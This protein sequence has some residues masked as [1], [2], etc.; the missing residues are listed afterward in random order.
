MATVQLDNIAKSWGAVTAV[1]PLSLDIADGEFLVLLGPSG[2][3]KTTTM[4]MIAGLDEPTGGTIRIDGRDV[5][6]LEPRDRDVAM[7][8]QNY[9]LYPHMTVAENIAY[10]LKL[11]GVPRAER[12]RRV[13]EAAARVE[14][15]PYLDRRPAAMSGGQRQ[16][17]A[18]ARAIVRQ[19]RLFL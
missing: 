6:H 9:G 17:V 15:T 5:T 14:L 19:A 2:C 8:F 10:P 7:V 11:A 16:R 1:S 12:S 13:A 18:L 3:G 4:R